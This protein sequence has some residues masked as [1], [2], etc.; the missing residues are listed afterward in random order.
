MTIIA[1]ARMGRSHCALLGRKK[2]VSQQASSTLLATPSRG[3]DPNLATTEP[4]LKGGRTAGS[5]AR[6]LR[7]RRPGT[8]AESLVEG[9]SICSNGDNA[10]CIPLISV[11]QR[12]SP[13]KRQ[14]LYN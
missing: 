2:R 11:P 12:R 8:P 1:A 3:E 10:P 14:P 6:N 13:T 5:I 9:G 4:L 7:R